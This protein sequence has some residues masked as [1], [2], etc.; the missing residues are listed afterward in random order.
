MQETK[1][2]TSPEKFKIIVVHGTFAASSTTRG[3]I[4]WQ[5]DSKFSDSLL[6]FFDTEKYEIKWIALD[7]SGKN[8]EQERQQAVKD[9]NKSFNTLTL[10]D[11]CTIA[12]IGHS[13]A[14]NIIKGAILYDENPI[15]LL[16][17]I[18]F[19]TV[20]TPYFTKNYTYYSS[21]K[22]S[23]FKIPGY[24]WIVDNKSMPPGTRFFLGSSMLIS[25]C[26][27]L[28]AILGFSIPNELSIFSI[29]IFIICFF[30]FFLLTSSLGNSQTESSSSNSANIFLA[31]L[32]QKLETFDKLKQNKDELKEILIKSFINYFELKSK[33]FKSIRGLLNINLVIE[34]LITTL[35]IE[36]NN[37]KLY[38][39]YDEA[40]NSLITIKK[41]TVNLATAR[42]MSLPTTIICTLIVYLILSITDSKL[43]I[44]DTLIENIVNMFFDYVKII[45]LKQFIMSGNIFLL[46]KL[47]ISYVSGLIISHLGINRFV[48]FIVNF[49][50]KELFI[51][52]AYGTQKGEELGLVSANGNVPDFPS[53]FIKWKPLPK[54]F[55]DEINELIAPNVDK[56]IRI[57]RESLYLSML[58]GNNNLYETIF[59]SI[60]FNEIVHTSY[61]NLDSFI[62]FIAWIFVKKFGFPPSEKFK[63]INSDKYEKWYEEISPDLLFPNLSEYF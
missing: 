52:Q 44:F 57:F 17:K 43:N 22:R 21:S 53:D 29:F 9:L 6:S 54:F 1:R 42:L 11:E 12:C 39:Q 25:G 34:Y 48:S 30:I 28:L 33:G 55:D 14:G 24:D 56:T 46:S 15:K 60:S 49:I 26:V 61:F 47:L 36:T 20:G 13:H 45:D 62:E 7:W 16:K 58:L 59:S 40:I 35:I 32:N 63:S 5:L 3:S 41:Q 37:P 50:I 19:L 27:L 18:Y 10:A 2:K 4:W 8:S 31:E 38:S 23:L 51:S